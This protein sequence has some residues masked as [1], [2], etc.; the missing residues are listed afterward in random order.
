MEDGKIYKLILSNCNEEMSDVNWKLWIPEQITQI[1]IERAHNSFT[2]AHGGVFKTL[3]KLKRL[4]YWPKMSVQV[5]NYISKCQVCKESKPSNQNL[6][7][8]IG[9]E[10]RTDRPFQKLYIDFLGKYPRSKMGNA[11]IFIVVDHFSKCIFI[12]PMKEAT[13]KNVIIFLV[14][15][16]F[17][18][19]VVPEIIHSDNGQQFISE[20]FRDMIE[21]YGIKHLITAFYSPQ[22]NASE[23]VNQSVLTAIRSYLEKDH[24]DWDLY[25]PKIECAI[26]TS[27]HTAIGTTSF[28]ALFGYHWFSNGAD[29]NLARK[30]KS[31]SD[32]EIITLN[33]KD[34]LE[35]IRDKIRQNI[36][37]AYNKSA[38]RCNERA[39]V[40]KF[41]P[42]QEVFRR[43]FAQS[44]FK[45]NV[46]AKFCSKFLKSRIIRP[47]GNSNV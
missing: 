8:T 35:I 14:L 6:R 11:Y 9:E 12:K 45:N 10:V 40:A 19:F 28:L 36:H 25:L 13:A 39:R 5:R 44:Y 20:T 15:E 23:S 32:H 22:S 31:V 18:K 29:Y 1:L 24:R 41:I 17:N 7:P 38:K 4:Y 46:N 42:G 16:V 37:E 33:R 2:S 21:T 34:R 3:N 47:I 26:R 27:V 43:N 30:L